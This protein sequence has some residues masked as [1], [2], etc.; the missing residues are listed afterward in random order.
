MGKQTQELS[1]HA[2]RVQLHVKA[3]AHSGPPT[4]LVAITC[5]LPNQANQS[6]FLAECGETIFQKLCFLLQCCGIW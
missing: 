3:A 6:N 2:Q 4:L 5:K 1:V